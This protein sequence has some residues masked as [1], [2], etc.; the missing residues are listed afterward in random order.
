MSITIVGYGT[1]GMFNLTRAWA[2]LA[3]RGQ[4]VKVCAPENLRGFVERSGVADAPLPIDVRALL[5]TARGAGEAGDLEAW[6]SKGPP[7]IYIGFGSMPVLDGR[8]RWP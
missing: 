8:G 3:Q 7:P 5:S 2:G 4:Q 6:L 1:R